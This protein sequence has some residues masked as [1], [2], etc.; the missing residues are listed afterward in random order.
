MNNAKVM[1]SIR[2]DGPFKDYSAMNSGQCSSKERTAA[3]VVAV[4][5]LAVAVAALTKMDSTASNKFL[6]LMQISNIILQFTFS[7]VYISYL[8]VYF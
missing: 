7:R 4:A 1:N 3:A 8:F 5:A 2:G 6:T